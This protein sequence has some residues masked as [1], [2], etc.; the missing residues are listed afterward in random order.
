MQVQGNKTASVPTLLVGFGFPPCVLLI[1]GWRMGFAVHD[2][3][4]GL[5]AY[6][7]LVGPIFLAA[8]GSTVNPTRRDR[9][10][11]LTPESPASMQDMRVKPRLKWLSFVGGGV[12][13]LTFLSVFVAV[14]WCGAQFEWMSSHEWAF[15]VF[16]IAGYFLSAIVFALAC[17]QFNWMSWQES[18]EYLIRTTRRKQQPWPESWLEPDEET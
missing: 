8:L 10:F 12:S 11:Q 3:K 6:L 4:F 13:V 2:L 7:C 14:I 15:A 16:P 1:L 5:L 17:V 18:K 9:S